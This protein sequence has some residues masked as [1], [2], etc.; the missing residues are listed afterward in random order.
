VSQAG[1]DRVWNLVERG[2]RTFSR[3]TKTSRPFAIPQTSDAARFIPVKARCELGVLQERPAH[4]D[5][6]GG[7]I[8]QVIMVPSPI[9]SIESI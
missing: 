1:V 6:I 3:S 9:L 5:R 2:G 7:Q 8:T 4:Q